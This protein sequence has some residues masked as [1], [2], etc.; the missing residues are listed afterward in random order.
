MEPILITALGDAN[1]EV[2]KTAAVAL[3]QIKSPTARAM[4]SLI[5]TLGDAEPEVRRGAGEA[6]GQI[7][8]AAVPALIA[9][10]SDP[11]P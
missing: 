3:G 9:V 4:S 2:R 1:P 6:L 7:G 11:N 10:L 8:P 5:A